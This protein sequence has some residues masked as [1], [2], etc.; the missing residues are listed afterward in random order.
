MKLGQTSVV[1]F[2]SQLLSSVVGFV[3]T[4]YLARVLGADL[5]GSYFL[6]VAVVIWLR[7]VGIM[8]I[9]TAITKRLSEA[10]G[11]DA[12]RTAGGLLLAAV[13]VLIGAALLSL[14]GLV[15][16]YV[17][18]PV[19]ELVAV[20]VFVGIALNFVTASLRGEHRV[21]LAALLSPVERS[22]R[23][24]LQI[25]AAAAGL[26]LVGVLAGWVVAAAVAALVG[27]YFVSGSF[28]RPARRHFRGLLDYARYA[29]IGK[30]GSRAFA[31]MDTVVLGAF[32]AT[33]LIGYY[34][35]AWNLASILALFGT[36]I[37]QA[38]FPEISRVATEGDDERLRAIL[39]D[40]LSYSGLLLIPGLVGAAAVGDRVLAIYGQEFAR[41]YVVLL[42]LVVARTVYAYG[43]QFLNVLNGIDRPD[44]AFRVNVAFLVTNVG[45]NVVL[46][47][48]YGW[49]GAAV[50]TAVSS[51]LTLALSYRLVAGLVP[52]DVPVAEIA[53]QFAAAAVMGGVVY[54]GRE[55]V[56]GGVF[57]TVGLVAVGG[58][59]YFG[60]LLAVSARLRTTVRRN[61]PFLPAP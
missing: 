31:S 35:I 30:L 55:A 51:G 39:D 59:V 58:A 20:M 29:W 1:A 25:G 49:T 52:V 9:H 48:V 10:D 45:L 8:G 38:L 24:V 13:A 34:E 32:V 60:V 6:V 11:D 54:A 57:V 43:N 7:V 56:G 5:L 40:A 44:L 4:L 37:S 3:A 19:A 21:H 61:L 16:S 14:S 42:V 12:Y 47:S 36:S 2:G 15:E 22:V 46:V 27:L 50:A 53:R 33:N 18:Y 28:E 41:A 23:G 26:G 17:G